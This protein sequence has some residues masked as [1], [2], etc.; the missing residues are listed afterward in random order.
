MANDTGSSQSSVRKKIRKWKNTKAR[1]RRNSIP[2]ATS[3]DHAA[4]NKSIASISKL[5]KTGRMSIEIGEHT[6]H[7][8]NAPNGTKATVLTVMRSDGYRVMHTTW[9]NKGASGYA[10][11]STK[12][13][14]VKD[15]QNALRRIAERYKKNK[16]PF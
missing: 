7:I 16:A 1:Q 5:G 3:I 10:R 11:T 13:E 12:N 6:Y 15:A 9:N 4:I 2:Q 14:A 8:S